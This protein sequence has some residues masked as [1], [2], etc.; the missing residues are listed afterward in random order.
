ML[1]D[2]STSTLGSCFDKDDLVQKRDFDNDDNNNNVFPFEP[3]S[4]LSSS[5]SSTG[6]DDCHYPTH[7]SSQ[8]TSYNCL[9]EEIE[10]LEQ[11]LDD[12]KVD[13][14]NNQAAVT[15]FRIDVIQN[16]LTIR[17]LRTNPSKPKKLRFRSIRK[18]SLTSNILDP[19]QHQKKTVRF[20][21]PPSTPFVFPRSR[22]PLP[23][24]TSSI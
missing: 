4:E 17:D 9:M 12:V 24:T 14:L 8:E 19:V 3:Y 6:N 5:T 23:K 2:D 15:A 22:F 21:L 20:Q 18:G 10:Q 11:K 16:I 7:L 13:L 1:L